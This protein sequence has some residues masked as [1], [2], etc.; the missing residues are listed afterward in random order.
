M[1]IPQQ[2]EV[3]PRFGELNAKRSSLHAEKTA[4]VA[5]AAV[6]RARIQDSPSAG[7]AAE[8]RVR[9]ILGESL[10]PDSA[11]DLLRLEA[12]LTELSTLNAAL[13]KLDGLIEK[14]KS[15]ASRLICSE[16][17]PE[18][19]RLGKKFAK[20]MLD[21]HAAH[22]EYI[23]FLDAVEDTGASISSL[24]RVWPSGLGHFADRSGTY[25]YAFR[26]FH[27]AGLIDAASIPEVVR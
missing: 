22:S 6:I 15:I 24:G 9:A 21:L 3:N 16:V 19:T 14:E 10:L 20:A 8:N 7:N 26:E 17:K 4:K 12:L 27:E 1:K 23:K 5:E 2:V 25:H 13:G 11:P 18:A